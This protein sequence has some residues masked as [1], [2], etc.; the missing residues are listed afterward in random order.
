MRFIGSK[1]DLLKDIEKIINDNIFGN[2]QIF[3]DLFAG[4]NVVGDYFKKN[5]TIISN[6]ILYFSYINGKAIIENN[7]NL[8]FGV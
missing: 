3:L 5:Y 4:T 1:T 8:A 7:G 2:E 6:D